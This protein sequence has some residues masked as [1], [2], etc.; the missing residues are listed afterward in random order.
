MRINE[1]NIVHSNLVLV[2]RNIENVWQTQIC[3]QPCNLSITTNKNYLSFTRQQKCIRS[4][5]PIY[6]SY[7]KRPEAVTVIYTSRSTFSPI[8]II[9]DMHYAKLHPINWNNTY[10]TKIIKINHL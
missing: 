8:F 6:S 3:N 2:W 9:Q 1:I 4:I 10:L 5:L 7:T